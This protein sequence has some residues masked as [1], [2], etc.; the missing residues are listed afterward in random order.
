MEPKSKSQVKR[1]NHQRSSP[2]HSAS[3]AE[4]SHLLNLRYRG[5]RVTFGADVDPTRKQPC[6]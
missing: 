5:V 2:P 4:L 1:L 3:G 6:R